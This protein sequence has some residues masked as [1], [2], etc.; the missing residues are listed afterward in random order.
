[1]GDIEYDPNT[2]K[3]FRYWLTTLDDEDTFEALYN[4]VRPYS[5]SNERSVNNDNSNQQSHTTNTKKH[6]YGCY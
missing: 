5:Q 4:I 2:D 3:T 1:M 6:N